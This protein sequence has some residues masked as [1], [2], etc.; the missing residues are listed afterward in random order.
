MIVS[1]LPGR[2]LCVP[3]QISSSDS[4]AYRLQLDDPDLIKLPIPNDRVLL[5]VEQLQIHEV[6][7]QAQD[8]LATLDLEIARA[9]ATYDALVTKREK[10][11]SH[12]ARLQAMVALQKALPD[13][14]L[15]E[16]FVLTAS[17]EG[18]VLVLPLRSRHYR[19]IRPWVL[20]RVYSR[21][22]LAALNE[23]CLWNR[24]QLSQDLRS[25]PNP[26]MPAAE[27]VLRRS[28]R[29]L[30]D[31]TVHERSSAKLFISIIASHLNRIKTL[32][33]D[34]STSF[35]I[36]FLSLPS[37]LSA[38]EKI[39]INSFLGLNCLPAVAASSRELIGYANSIWKLD[40]RAP[41]TSFPSLF[42]ISLES[43]H[44]SSV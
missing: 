31:L 28:G 29:S 42:S 2:N 13:E 36:G 22:R 25:N 21:W 14:I 44:I 37:A 18:A 15:A 41:P 10:H 1:L 32:S 5:P 35:M 3:H 17:N 11:T 9:K 4:A 20:T 40:I 26:I 12:M 30:L 23:P 6:L 16:I 43:A 38:L 39:T 27:E 8:D 7:S 33:L 19:V 34:V 24:V